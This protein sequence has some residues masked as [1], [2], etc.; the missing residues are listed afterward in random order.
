MALKSPHRD[1]RLE[2][3]SPV[4]VRAIGL[5]QLLIRLWLRVLFENRPLLARP[6]AFQTVAELANEI[7]RRSNDQFRGFDEA[8]GAAET[9]LR[10]DLVKTLRRTPDRFTVARPVHALATRIRS[11]DRQTDDSSASL[12]IYSWLEHVDRELLSELRDFIEV[13]VGQESVDLATYALALLGSE[14]PPD[15]MRSDTPAEIP[16]PVCLGQA[17]TYAEDVRRLLAYRDAIPRSALVDH[18]RRLTGFHLGL[19]L[20]RLFRAVVEVEQTGVRSCEACREGRAPG[21]ETC[22]YRLELLVDCGEDARSR[23]AKLAESSWAIQEDYLARYIRCHLAL[24]KLHEF[25]A[26]LEKNRPADAVPFATLSEVAA[27]EHAAR[28]ELID[29]FFDQRI[30][31]LVADSGSGEEAERVAEL[32]RDYRTMGL[33]PL[34]VYVALLAHSSERRWF[35]YHRYL[36]DSLFAKNSSDG[37]LRQPLGGKRRR[38]GALGA[39]L[40]ETLALIAVVDEAESGYFT[41]PLRVDQLIERL[42]KRYDL[43]VG[44]PPRE[45]AADLEANRDVAGNVDRFKARLRE[46]GLFTDLSDAFLAQL[47]RP[48][49]TLARR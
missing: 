5:D 42:E 32:E 40:L 22:P 21:S 31:Q 15:M 2:A 48:R 41:R 13:D 47:V 7:E 43:L 38:R 33:S 26:Y 6:N 27:V 18:L 44:R 29:L 35:N 12:A 16:R 36:L 14:Q 37:M 19:Y 45:L 8:E 49:H 4:D 1:W 23:V 10:A 3:I 11:V 20:L 34:R 24:K 28:A 39:A 46:T 30:E 25:A 9:W 17:K